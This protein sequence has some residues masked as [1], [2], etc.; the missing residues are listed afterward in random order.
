MAMAMAMVMVMERLIRRM[1]DRGCPS[2]D[3]KQAKIS[4]INMHRVR[5][6]CD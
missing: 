4:N 1:I 5:G 2:V 6:F 3:E